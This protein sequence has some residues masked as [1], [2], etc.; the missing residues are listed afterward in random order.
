MIAIGV[1]RNVKTPFN[2][3]QILVVVPKNHRSRAIVV[4]EQGLFRFGGTV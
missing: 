3:S 4:E 1:E 2:P